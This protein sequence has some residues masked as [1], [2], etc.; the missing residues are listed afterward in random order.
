MEISLE[1]YNAMAERLAYLEQKIAEREWIPVSYHEITEE[2]RDEN[3]YPEYW[4]YLLDCE[5]PQ[6]EQEILVQAKNGE[7]RWD[8]CYLD[9]EFSLD[10]GWDWVDEIV[11]WMPLPEPYKGGDD[12]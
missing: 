2:E 10:S 7:I 9:G 8:V 3:G 5:M 6:D 4:V 12:E 1:Q 11:A